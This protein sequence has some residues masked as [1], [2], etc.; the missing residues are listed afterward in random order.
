MQAVLRVA[1]IRTIEAA[2][3]AQLPPGTL[4]QRA[5]QAIADWL[6]AHDD[7]PVLFLAG[8]GNNG[9]D[10][11]EAATRLHQAF[12]QVHVLYSPRNE[13]AHRTLPPDS[14]RAITRAQSAGVP[15]SDAWPKHFHPSVI[16][17]GLFG[18]G[19][20]RAITGVWAQWIEHARQSHC[21]L[22]AIDVPSGIDADSG[23]RVGGADALAIAATTTLTF[24]A[25]KPGLHMGAGADLAGEVIV[26]N[27]GCTS[28]SIALI[29]PGLR[30]DPAQFNDLWAPRERNTHK[31]RFG[32]LAVIGASAG[33]TG[34]GL[35][36]A[37]TAL[38]AGAG[39]VFLHPLDADVKLDWLH[40]EI[41][42]RARDTLQAN[43]VQVI[44]PGLGTSDAALH[45]LTTA[46][47]SPTPVVLDADALNLVSVTPPVAAIVRS[48][49]EL[50]RTT[51]MTP[52]PL[53]AARLL[54]TTADE[55]QAD[56]LRAARA[57]AQAFSA[58]VVLKG[59]GSII[60]APAGP[61]R[62]NLT[63]NPGLASGGTGDVLAGLL[64]ALIAQHPK[65]PTI[66]TVSG[67]VWLHGRA[68]D[69]LV[70]QGVGPIGL[71]ASELGPALRSLLNA[72]RSAAPLA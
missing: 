28:A 24:I 2:E 45:L 35:L 58:V 39:R 19:L 4:M 30:T 60:C 17:D 54:G 57:L 43:A 5:G 9:G 63:G 64:G 37:R 38:L 67:G 42:V 26:A 23:A 49:G 7:G 20:Q 50:G 41:M 15:I 55:I 44:G 46:L 34:A 62:I 13:A 68:A 61:W 48:R 18:I 8:P 53:E 69:T 10:A 31:G 66:D 29:D 70:E 3:A 25:D 6:I 33:M 11:F 71:T 65:A 32:D 1:D 14:A 16:V 22:I 52:H 21:P 59:A 36:A 56:R 40:P 72:P 27:L 12:R 51:V 47:A